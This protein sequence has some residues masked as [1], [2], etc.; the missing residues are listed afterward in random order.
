MVVNF[1]IVGLSM[2]VFDC[3]RINNLDDA[4]VSNIN[5]KKLQSSI[6]AQEILGFLIEPHWDWIYRYYQSQFGRNCRVPFGKFIIFPPKWLTKD[7]NNGGYC[8][9]CF[10]LHDTH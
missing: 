2:G 8:T 9:L 4:V 1:H 10:I 3:R 5:K 7:S 6:R